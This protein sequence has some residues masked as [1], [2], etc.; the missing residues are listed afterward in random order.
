MRK[1]GVYLLLLGHL[2]AAMAAMY[3]SRPE[4]TETRAREV[5]LTYQPVTGSK[6]ATCRFWEAQA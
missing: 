2:Q 3:Y 4:E 6:E 1:V 5:A